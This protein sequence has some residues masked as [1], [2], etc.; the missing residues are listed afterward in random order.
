MSHIAQLDSSATPF[1]NASATPAERLAALP[2]D[3]QAALFARVD[4]SVPC[5]YVV[6]QGTR[7]VV[8]V[9]IEADATQGD[10][11]KLLSAPAPIVSKK[12]RAPYVTLCHL[13]QALLSGAAREQ[14]LR[15]GVVTDHDYARS[16]KH[17]VSP[18]S[19]AMLDFDDGDIVVDGKRAL[20]EL[21]LFGIGYTSWSYGTAKHPD[22]EPDIISLGGRL[23]LP[24]D[25]ELALEEFKRANIAAGWLTG[26]FADPAA[27]VLSQAQGLPVRRSETA[28]VQYVRGSGT[29]CLRVHGLLALYDLLPS[30]TPP[31]APGAR[32]SFSYS[33]VIARNGKVASKWGAN[34]Y[35][36]ILPTD[37]EA[38][39][40]E[41]P[42]SFELFPSYEDYFRLA[43]HAHGVLRVWRD[44]LAAM[45]EL[46]PEHLA[47][48]TNAMEERVRQAWISFA[49]QQ[50]QDEQSS[51]ERKWE[52]TANPPPD[53]AGAL[54]IV[55]AKE[56]DWMMP[57]RR[58]RPVTVTNPVTE[59]TRAI[60]DK[61]AADELFEDVKQLYRIHRSKDVAFGKTL[62]LLLSAEPA[63]ARRA[64]T[65][66]AMS[67]L[68]RTT[69][70]ERDRTSKILIE[71]ADRLLGAGRGDS[72]LVRVNGRLRASP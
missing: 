20:D 57:S 41:V 13:R 55:K 7:T 35:D 44:Q 2:T 1:V 31:A 52:D 30:L 39:F 25:R 6:W 64:L 63:V 36:P 43:G 68:A 47:F 28:Q 33:D 32:R 69:D 16:N 56:A 15:R 61:Q 29:R 4:L 27:M 21:G 40:Y 11:V 50:P 23:W 46:S 34:I 22:T 58:P 19:G 5:P 10:F 38:F 71:A 12:D 59:Q 48:I 37:V 72:W 3:L 24:F 9:R 54:F 62:H 49:N 66:V 60:T 18:G 17:V 67:V 14:Y 51:P 42:N 26:G 8:P 65:R 45:G 53:V 70:N